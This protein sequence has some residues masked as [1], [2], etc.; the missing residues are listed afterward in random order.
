MRAVVSCALGLIGVGVVLV[1]APARVHADP[2]LARIAAVGGT[3]MNTGAL[4]DRYFIGYLYGV[5]AAWQP[6]EIGPVRMGASWWLTHDTYYSSDDTNVDGTLDLWHRGL[7]A[8][9]AIKLPLTIPLDVSVQLGGE[10]ARTTAPVPPD[11][12][13]RY[14]GPT[15]ALGLELGDGTRFVALSVAYGLWVGGPSGVSVMVSVGVGAR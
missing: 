3:R 13:Q 10:L 15:G 14:F 4:G 9:A 2:S 6:L 11:Q 1:A 7:G 12:S 5:E 8:R